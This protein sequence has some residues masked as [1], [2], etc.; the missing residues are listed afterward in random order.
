MSPF[1]AHRNE[2]TWVCF[3]SCVCVCVRACLLRTHVCALVSV[4]VKRSEGVNV[5][6]LLHVWSQVPAGVITQLHQL[7]IGPVTVSGSPHAAA[8]SRHCTAQRQPPQ[9]IPSPLRIHVPLSSCVRHRAQ[10]RGYGDTHLHTWFHLHILYSHED[11]H[12]CRNTNNHT[13]NNSTNSQ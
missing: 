12:M 5:S 13:H 3:H 1:L 8:P 2:H 10:C 9:A 7:L 4:T 6:V 11:K